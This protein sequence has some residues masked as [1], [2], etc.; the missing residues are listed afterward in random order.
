MT[1]TG[2]T[3]RCSRQLEGRPGLGQAR[4]LAPFLWALLGLFVLRVAGQVLVAFA[5]VAFLPPMQEWYSGLVPYKYLLP[6]QV[7]IIVLMAKIC[8]DFTREQGFFADPRRFFATYWLAFG[9]LYLAAMVV[10]YRLQIYFHPE[11]R[12]FGGIIPIIFHWVLAV[13]VIV[14]GLHHRRQLSL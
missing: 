3:R 10:R 11:R 8:A 7:A 12:W 6:A 4:L 5:G 14:V 13:F 1:G 9:W 2:T